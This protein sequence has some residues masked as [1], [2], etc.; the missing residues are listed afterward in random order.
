VKKTIFWFCIGLFLST[1]LFIEWSV[2]GFS[3]LPYIEKKMGEQQELATDG[4]DTE[5]RPLTRFSGATSSMVLM[6]STAST[7]IINVFNKKYKK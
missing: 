5:A 3:D 4:G 2:N 6:G 7:V 1:C